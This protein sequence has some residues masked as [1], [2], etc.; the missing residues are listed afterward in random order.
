MELIKKIKQ[1]E[2]QAQEIID[3]AKAE[4]AQAAE[5][6]RQRRRLLL[7][8][9]QQQRKKATDAAIAAARKQGESEVENLKVRAEDQRRELHEQVADRIDAASAKVIDYLKG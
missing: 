3:Q 8:E 5:Q 9:A 7:E 6:G 1:S 4:A 2:A